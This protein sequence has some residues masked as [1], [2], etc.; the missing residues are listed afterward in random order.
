MH[1]RANNNLKIWYFS[2]VA[3][4]LMAM[5]SLIFGTKMST[6]DACAACAKT[7]CKKDR[8]FCHALDSVPN[9]EAATTASKVRNETI[10]FELRLTL[11]LES[12][13]NRSKKDITKPV[14]VLS[15][16]FGERQNSIYEYIFKDFVRLA[17]VH[18]SHTFSDKYSSVLNSWVNEYLNI[19]HNM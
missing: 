1:F 12:K 3:D 5:T 10:V 11:Q 13:N 8:V 7:E 2:T 18:I 4:F 6:M 16:L 15:Y 19:Y 17:P 14:F 9:R